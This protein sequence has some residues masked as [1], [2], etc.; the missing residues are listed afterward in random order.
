MFHRV[1]INGVRGLAGSV[2]L[3]P[4]AEWLEGRDVRRKRRLFAEQ[5][6]VPFGV[7]R[8]RS[9]AATIDTVRFAAARVPYYR[10]LFAGLGFEP[11]SLLRDPRF[12]KDIPFL[13][14]DI[15]RSEGSRLLREDHAD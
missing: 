7:R 2:I 1:L 13:T 6:A 3:F 4:V 11:D 10:D 5:M 9:W 12:L 15:I 8:A 14:K